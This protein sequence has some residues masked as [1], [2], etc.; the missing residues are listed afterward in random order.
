MNVKGPTPQK[1]Y[2]QIQIE[3]LSVKTSE[4]PNFPCLFCFLFSK[5]MAL[6]IKLTFFI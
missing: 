4:I 6:E 1:L 3:I 5:Q 2:I